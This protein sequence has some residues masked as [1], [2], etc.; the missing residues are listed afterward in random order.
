MN[1]EFTD[2]DIEEFIQVVYSA[3]YQRKLDELK[4]RMSHYT[5]PPKELME[6]YNQLLRMKKQNNKED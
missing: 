6:E 4:H 1:M 2:V 3:N 5:E